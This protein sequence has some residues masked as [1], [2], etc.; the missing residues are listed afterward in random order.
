M[1][2]SFFHALGR[3]LFK[4][5]FRFKVS[6]RENIPREGAV[7][8]AA[9]HM[10]FLDPISIGIAS[11]RP[12]HFMARKSLFQGSFFPWLITRLNAFPLK[13]EG[14]DPSSLKKA[15]RILKEGKALLIFPEGTRSKDG[16]IGK[17]KGGAGMLA[18]KSGAVVVPTLITGT[19][20]ALPVDARWIKMRRVR[21][22][23]DRPMD[24]SKYKG[25]SKE[26]YQKVSEEIMERIRNMKEK[27]G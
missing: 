10:S 7:L 4:I 22:F 16:N 17:V 23:F 11:P 13:R 2:Y 20:K 15:L 27:V 19:D 21:V 25:R 6:G 12:I 8:I 5:L 14:V 1:L 26:V 24:L 3:V 18:L 9:N